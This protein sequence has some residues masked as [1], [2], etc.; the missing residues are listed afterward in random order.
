MLAATVARRATIVRPFRL[1]AC[2]RW[3][4]QAASL[5]RRRLRADVHVAKSAAATAGIGHAVSVV[6]RQA[7]PPV[8]DTAGPVRLGRAA[9]ADRAK[10]SATMIGTRRIAPAAG[11]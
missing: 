3:T 8:L 5:R 6:C 11:A 9:A 7:E 4:Q 2:G 10:G 1:S